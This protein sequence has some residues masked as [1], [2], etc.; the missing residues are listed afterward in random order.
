M[1]YHHA[2]GSV[3]HGIV[4]MHIEEGRLKNAG[5]ETYFVGS[6]VIVSIYGLGCHQP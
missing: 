6:W 1:T 4:G 5:R 3:V 2:Y